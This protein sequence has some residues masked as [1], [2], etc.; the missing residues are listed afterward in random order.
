[1]ALD[2]LPAQVIPV[3]DRTDMDCF[4]GLPA[5]IRQAL[6]DTVQ[7]WDARSACDALKTGYPAEK[8][9]S[10]IKN[11]DRDFVRQTTILR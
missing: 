6:R 9:V 1:M 2:R 3:D 4:D 5:Q 8:L 7:K 11:L 10:F